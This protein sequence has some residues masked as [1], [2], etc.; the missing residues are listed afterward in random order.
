MKTSL[1]TVMETPT[2][3]VEVTASGTV[4]AKNHLL[5]ISTQAFFRRLTPQERASLRSSSNVVRDAKED[6][7]R[8]DMVQLDE[9]VRTLLTDSELFTP[10]RVDELMVLGEGHEGRLR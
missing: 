1:Q 2:H 6:L 10:E 3:K 8:G 9:V 5:I 4:N 7:D